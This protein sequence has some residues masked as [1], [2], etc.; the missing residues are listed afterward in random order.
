MI[1]AYSSVQYVKILEYC[2]NSSGQKVNILD[3][4]FT[5]PWEELKSLR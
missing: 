4:K 5:E 1:L 2:G 3:I